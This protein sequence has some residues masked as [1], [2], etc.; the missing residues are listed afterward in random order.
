M[1][2]RVCEENSTQVTPTG[3]RVE[4]LLLAEDEGVGVVGQASAFLSL[5]VSGWVQYPTISSQPLVWFCSS[6][7]C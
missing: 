7:A 3:G 5:I 6:L 4:T 1:Q 2:V